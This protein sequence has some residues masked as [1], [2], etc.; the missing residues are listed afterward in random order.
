MSCLFVVSGY[1]EIYPVTLTGKVVCVIYASVGIPLM[2]LVIL[3]VGDF[4]A[5]VMSKAYSKFHKLCKAFRCNTWPPWKSWKREVD[6]SLQNLEDD[7]FVMSQD[8]VVCKPLDIRQVMHSQA[9]VR[10]KSLRLQKNKDIFE[11]IIAREELVRKNPLLRSLSCPELD[12]QPTLN[13]DF[14][15][16]DFSGLGDGM[17][18]LDVPFLLILLVVTL[19]ICL[20]ANVLSL[21]EDNFLGFDS[22][23]F[24]FI[25]LTTIG[26]G[27][28]V[29]KHREYFM[30][31][32]L[33][34]IIGMTIMSMAFKLS[35]TRIVSFYRKCIQ[36]ISRGN[37]V[38]FN[39]EKSN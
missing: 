16:W 18:T 10:N 38:K 5:L 17:E 9:D 7:G 25:T 24:C 22:Y 33:F 36:F 2:L 28:I 19:Y 4:L 26:F 27:D 31:I 32:S 6:S 39:K 13:S 3:D 23:Y 29:P 21:W 12:R 35:Q 8:I 20:G 15:I 11:K 30:F 37:A 34:I 14:A 1:G